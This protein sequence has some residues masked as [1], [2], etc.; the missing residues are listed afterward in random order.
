[1]SLSHK[2]TEDLALELGLPS[3]KIRRV[4]EDGQLPEPP[5]VAGRRLLTDAD[6]PVIVEALTARGWLPAPSQAG[7]QA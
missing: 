5:R 7:A 4:F 2:S 6:V 1:M 3:W